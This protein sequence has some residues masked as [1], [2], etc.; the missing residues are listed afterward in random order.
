MIITIIFLI[1]NTLVKDVRFFDYNLQLLPKQKWT[2]VIYRGCDITDKVGAPELPVKP[3]F[4]SLPGGSKIKDIRILKK[5]AEDITGTYK[6]S[7]ARPQTILLQKKIKKKKAKPLLKIYESNRPYPEKLIEIKGCGLWDNQTVYELLVYPIQYLP[8]SGKLILYKNIQFA[9]DYIPG[10]KIPAKTE[11]IKKMVINP[12][13]VEFEPLRQLGDFDYVIIT[14][15]PLDTI[16]QRLADWKTKKGVRTEVRIKSWILS[17]YP[18]EDEPAKIRN[19][20]KTLPDSG[21][22]YVLLG[23]DTDVIPCRFAYAMTC[24][25]GYQPG[26]EDTMPADLYFADLQGTWDEDNDGSYGEIEDSVDLYPDVFVGRAPVNTIAEAQKFVEKVLIY[27]KNPSLN[28]LTRAMFAADVLWS[29]PYTDQGIHKNKIG[30]ESFPQYFDITKL[31]YSQGN[32]SPNAVKNSL[33]QGKGM[34]NHDGHGWIN[35]IGCGTG[36]LYTQDFDTLTNAP[37]YGIFCSIGCWTSAFDFNSISESFVNSPQGGGVAYIGN[38]SYGWGSP[39]NPGFGYSDRFDSRIFY[40]LFRENNFHLGACLALAKAH[41]IP[42]SREKNVYRW[43]QYEVNLLGDPELPVWTNTPESLLVSY[44][45]SIPTGNTRILITVRNKATAAPV[46]NALVCLMKQNESYDKGYTDASGSIFLNA[47]A[48]TSGDF[49]LTISAHNFIPR[50][51]TIPVITGSYISFLGW[52]I[53][54]SSGNNDGIANPNEQILLNVTLKNSGSATAN[55]VQLKLRTQDAAVAIQDSLET[56]GTLNSGDSITISGAFNLS[57]DSTDN[58]HGISSE[59]EIIEDTKTLVYNPIIL[60]GTPVF[61]FPKMII[62]QP[63]TL[64]GDSELVFLRVKNKGFGYAHSPYVLLNSADSCVTILTDSIS[65]SDIPPESSDTIGPFTVFVHSDCPTGHHPVLNFQINA[66][67]YTYSR[68]FSLIVGE[69]GFSDDMESDS[70]LWTTGG[71]NNLWHIST[72]RSFS[73]SHSWYCGQ[74]SNGQY[75]NNM[76]CYIQTVPFMVNENSILKFYRWFNVPIYGADGIYV[77]VMGDSFSDTLDFIGTGGALE[78]REIQSNW[79][80]EQYSLASYSGGD[81]IR[82]RIAFISDG[83]NKVGEGFYIDDVNIQYINP[84]N[85][86]SNTKPCKPLL[87]LFPNPFQHKLYYI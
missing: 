47:T 24:S 76:N 65:V 75:V 53:D 57:I 16:F 13:D 4:I 27:E 81:T 40:S 42:Y 67:G 72:R 12:E 58:G 35:K 69:T 80:E 85:I 83:D 11:I 34:S 25:A 60:V 38:S 77:I 43:H 73:P 52:Q 2:K 9:I 50:E 56:V 87:N 84:V 26:R 29:N 86:Y 18:G 14:N 6:V 36:Y 39:G 70:S 74:D 62:N 48:Q 63:P 68:Y 20:I 8:S 41:F 54:D 33:R 44:P 15:P 49:D 82:L 59:M 3:I 30:D 66:E 46:R 45:N 79:F 31:Y 23:G 55:N 5:E 78:K 71:T 19:Y 61:E 32:L 17:H 22:K 21:V 28:Y 51:I 7:W 64:P 10:V 1:G 37:Y